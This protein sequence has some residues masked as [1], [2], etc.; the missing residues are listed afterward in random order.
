MT[1]PR[2]RP[3]AA[4]RPAGARSSARCVAALAWLRPELAPLAP[5]CSRYAALRD[6]ARG[7]RGV[8]AGA[9]RR[10]RADRVPARAC[11]ATRCRSRY[12]A[13][14]G[15]LGHGVRYA[16]DRRACW[17]P[18]SSASCC[19]ALRRAARRQRGDRA[20]GGR[21]ARALA[22]GRARGRRLDAGLSSVRAG[23]AALRAARRRSARR[24]LRLARGRGWP[25][26]LRRAR[27]ARCRRVDLATRI[28]RAARERATAAR[29]LRRSRAARAHARTRGAA[30]TSATS[31]TRAASRSSTWAASPIRAIA[32]M[33]GGHLAQAH[34]RR[35]T[36]ARAIRTRSCCTARCR[37]G[38]A[39]AGEL[40]AFAGY[41]VERRHR[42]AA[43]RAR[44]L[45][46][47]GVVRFAPRL[48]LPRARA[49]G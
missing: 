36:C 2:S 44:A 13:K 19:A 29:R 48:P 31:A 35:R 33:P 18:R 37:R 7:R 3:R 23:A 8:R 6:R 38:S 41:P 39:P 22:R 30:S 43:V 12:R 49:L 45:S 1:S 34:R 40:L 4:L 28:A 42:G 32:R 24:A 27:A 20:L 17:R 16:A 15:S 14:P 25:R 21:A 11:S 47:A 46:R 26:S 9:R 10:A 5:C